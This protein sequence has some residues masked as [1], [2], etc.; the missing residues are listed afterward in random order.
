MATE[1]AMGC[2]VKVVP[3]PGVD[4]YFVKGKPVADY[5]ADLVGSG[6][7]DLS[8]AVKGQ[9]DQYLQ[10][11]ANFL[12]VKSYKLDASRTP[13]DT[14]RLFAGEKKS[15]YSFSRQFER[16]LA[17]R[18][19]P[20]AGAAA[21][22]I[23]AA[24]DLL[25]SDIE[26]S[27]KLKE[28]LKSVI[29]LDIRAD[30][31][32]SIDTAKITTL[33]TA[34]HPIPPHCSVRTVAD[35][36]ARPLFI[37]DFGGRSCNPCIVM[38]KIGTDSVFGF[39]AAGGT[40][41]PGDFQL[42]IHSTINFFQKIMFLNYFLIHDDLHGGNVMVDAK[43]NEMH[44]IDLGNAW[45]PTNMVPSF[46][47]RLTYG[48]QTQGSIERYI[49][50]ATRNGRFAGYLRN[51]LNPVEHGTE[52]A[53]LN[54]LV[55]RGATPYANPEVIERIVTGT[56]PEGLAAAF[57][58]C[59]QYTR[60]A[61]YEG[62]RNRLGGMR[63]QCVTPFYIDP[64]EGGN[65][66]IYRVSMVNAIKE[67]QKFHEYA[68]GN[69]FNFE[70][71]SKNDMFYFS[72]AFQRLVENDHIANRRVMKLF[73]MLFHHPNP[74]IRPSVRIIINIL[75]NIIKDSFHTI[76][77]K[78]SVIGAGQRAE[79][80]AG[81]HTLMKLA[82]VLPESETLNL[83]LCNISAV[84]TGVIE[85]HF[86]NPRAAK[87]RQISYFVTFH[88]LEALIDLFNLFGSRFDADRLTW[89]QLLVAWRANPI[90]AAA[91]ADRDRKIN[92]LTYVDFRT[93]FAN[94]SRTDAEYKAVQRNVYY[95]LFVLFQN[96]GEIWA[97][98]NKYQQLAPSA[99]ND[100]ILDRIARP[101]VT[102]PAAADIIRNDAA[103]ARVN[104]PDDDFTKFTRCVY[105]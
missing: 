77:F 7:V 20:P 72:S 63:Y 87:M 68:S 51:F 31:L 105:A 14:Y 102:I 47:N 50:A 25:A 59:T 81:G 69:D 49:S 96:H 93:I 52:L 78:K 6:I 76:I 70:I 100:A 43:F 23:K 28:I 64:S 1:G 32:Y 17:L 8:A 21:A 57:T 16:N 74:L 18:P 88:L 12:I 46:W 4:G 29:S 60:N 2:V 13:A 53:R 34:A 84:T 3:V 94:C 67:V 92:L 40:K 58:N 101:L 27:N 91:A 55:A 90:A 80:A 44:I 97:L 37:E 104:I 103:P 22:V 85:W 19:A 24:N 86:D 30:Q 65:R 73:G 42:G 71:N 99:A 45:P 10:R 38:C 11:Y 41:T 82:N 26:H 5:G 56:G 9:L 36:L 61:Y 33:S 89:Q 98:D 48:E 35:A 39:C 95:G 15:H 79:D 54:A 66:E 62:H 83:G 75:N